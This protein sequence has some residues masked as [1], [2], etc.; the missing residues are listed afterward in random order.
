MFLLGILA[1]NFSQYFFL[2]K[3][4]Y[5]S[6]TSGR[7]RN[8]KRSWG[9]GKGMG[10]EPWFLLPKRD[11]RKIGKRSQESSH[12]N[13]LIISQLACA[14]LKRS[15]WPTWPL[16]SQRN[17]LS[18]FL[19]ALVLPW[20]NDHIILAVINTVKELRRCVWPC[21]SPNVMDVTDGFVCFINL[22]SASHFVFKI[23]KPFRLNC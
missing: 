3:N 7:R 13:D 20:T 6:L 16:N 4:R 23:H 14:T 22:P 17:A 9:W 2:N 18:P 10:Q 21:P 5:Y 19:M 11:E 1:S 12:S 15:F 8:A